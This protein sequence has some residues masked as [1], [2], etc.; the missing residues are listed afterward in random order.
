MIISIPKR[1]PFSSL[2]KTDKFYVYAL[3]RCCVGISPKEVTEWKVMA[4]HWEQVQVE[5]T[6]KNMTFKF[7]QILY[8][9]YGFVQNDL[10]YNLTLSGN[11]ILMIIEKK[12]SSEKIYTDSCL[13]E[14]D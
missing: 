5:E 14:E 7:P 2:W 11:C 3:S 6:P 1:I 8:N 10:K 13:K 9:F 12:D 4:L